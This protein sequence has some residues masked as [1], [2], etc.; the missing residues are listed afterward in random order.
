MKKKITIKDIAKVANVSIGT[1]DRVIHNRGKVSEKA[2]QKVND[3]LKEL[4][5]KANPLARSLKN[6]VVYAISILVP[7]PQKDSYWLPCQQ[8]IMEI[9]T[10]YEAFDVDISVHNFDP[11]QPESFSKIGA[12]LIRK[13][14]D[15]VLFVPLFE[16]ESDVLLRKLNKKGILSATFNSMPRNHVDQHVGQD[17]YLSGRVG[18]KLISDFLDPSTSKIGIVHID[19]AFNNAIHMQQKEEGFKSFYETYAAKYDIFTKTINTDNI[20][21]TLLDFIESHGVNVFF[22]T[23]S[24]TYEVARTLELLNKNGIVV[25]YD[26]LQENIKY[27]TEGKIQF[28]IHQ[29]P[30]MQASLSLKSLVEKLLFKKEYP[31]KQFLPIEIINSENVK[32]YL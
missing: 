23:T 16:R 22:V 32:S 10:E 18:A 15:A 1:V 9:I 12:R 26:L 11:S 8:G 29:A 13:S 28:L 30:R 14:P 21:S 24:K 3:A 31:K 27:L 7:D 25:G 19:E 6:N 5:Y 4:D 2:L 20:H 17:L